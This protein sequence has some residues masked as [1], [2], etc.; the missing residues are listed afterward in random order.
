MQFLRPP[1]THHQVRQAPFPA[2]AK[3]HATSRPVHTIG[4][5]IGVGPTA[6]EA[7]FLPFMRLGGEKT[8]W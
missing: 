7:W 3:L 8:G 1:P 5:A 6:R 2:A 4:C